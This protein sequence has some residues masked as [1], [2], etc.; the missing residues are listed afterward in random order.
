MLSLIFLLHFP[1][2]LQQSGYL[3]VGIIWQTH[4]YTGLFIPLAH[5]CQHGVVASNK[6]LNHA[7]GLAGGHVVFL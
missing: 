5:E 2:N 4:L 1:I 3:F 6:K 7:I